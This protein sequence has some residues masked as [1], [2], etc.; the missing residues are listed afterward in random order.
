[1]AVNAETT[2]LMT[3]WARWKSGVSISAAVSS[4]Y[5]MEGHG[6]RDE[7]PTPLINGEAVDVDAA[8]K[9]LPA[10]LVDVVAVWWLRGGRAEDKAARCKC[11]VASL[12]RRLDYAHGR[13]R[14]HLSALRERGNR[15]RRDRE[16][17]IEAAR[18]AAPETLTNHVALVRRIH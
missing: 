8:V 16:A 10:E 5:N 13:I 17:A 6:R 12:Y 9:L 7:T 3:N 11:S 14:A 4:A 1:M 2:R 15:M 18:P